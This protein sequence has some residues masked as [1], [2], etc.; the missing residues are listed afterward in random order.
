MSEHY[1]PFEEYSE[2][3]ISNGGVFGLRAGEELVVLERGG[4]SIFVAKEVDEEAEPEAAEDVV[5][6]TVEAEP[7]PD[8]DPEPDPEI[9]AEAIAFA[10]AQQTPNE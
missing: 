5:E 7:E 10:E 1:G 2:V 8:A 6:E 9:S 4:V 3:M